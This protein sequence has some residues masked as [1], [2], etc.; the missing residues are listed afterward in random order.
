MRQQRLTCS[1]TMWET[2]L[3]YLVGVS[4]TGP[5][6]GGLFATAQSAWGT[7]AVMSAVQSAAMGGPG[8]NAAAAAGAAAGAVAGFKGASR[9]AAKL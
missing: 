8:L 4:S 5:V 7:T 2:L 3:G 1:P 9:L 6:A